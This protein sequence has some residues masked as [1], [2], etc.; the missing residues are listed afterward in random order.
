MPCVIAVM[1]RAVVLDI[2]SVLEIIDDTVFPAPFEQRHGL[3]AGAVH[4]AP[5]PFPATRASASSARRRCAR[6]GASTSR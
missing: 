2:G 1:I 4:E 5:R 3:P 6:T